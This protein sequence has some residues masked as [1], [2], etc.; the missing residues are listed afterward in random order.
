MRG[1]HAKQENRELAL[2]L[3]SDGYRGKRIHGFRCIRGI[4]FVHPDFGVGVKIVVGRIGE[5][6]IDGQ[7]TIA[8]SVG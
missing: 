7:V 2:Q 6:E 4:G 1:I 5:T 8:K 3:S